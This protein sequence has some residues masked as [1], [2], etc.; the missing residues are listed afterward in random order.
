MSKLIKTYSA[1]ALLSKYNRVLT[2]AAT[3]DLVSKGLGL[4]LQFHRQRRRQHRE[5]YDFYNLRF[6]P[7]AVPLGITTAFCQQYSKHNEKRFFRAVQ[8]GVDDE[9][10]R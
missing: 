10:K 4:L 8:Y 9:V 6:L 1:C 5:N 3:N 7:I 2:V